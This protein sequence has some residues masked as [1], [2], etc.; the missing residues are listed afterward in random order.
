MSI[1]RKFVFVPGPLES[2]CQSLDDAAL[3]RGDRL[4]RTFVVRGG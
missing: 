1:L 3:V 2:S 4:A